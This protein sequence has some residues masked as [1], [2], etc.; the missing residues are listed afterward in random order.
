M[1]EVTHLLSLTNVKKYFGAVRAVDGVS[2]QIG[3][4]EIVGVVGPNGAGKTTLINLISGE[5]IPD[6]G[7]IRF[8]DLDITFAPIH[9]RVKL[10]IARSYQLPQIFERLSVLE[11]VLAGLLSYNGH[12]LDFWSLKSSKKALIKRAEEIL[13]ALGL[14]NKAT[15]EARKLSEGE[16]K[17]LDVAIAL[18]LNPKLLLL[19]E[20][21]TSVSL[22][23]KDMVMSVLMKYIKQHSISSVIVEH[24]LEVVEKYLPSRVLVMNEGKVIY[25]G[26]FQGIRLDERVRAVVFGE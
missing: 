18:T 9:K 19:D 20:P 5:L 7:R 25:D 22:E 2:F 8:K 14:L 10:G 23:E 15:V 13:D 4:G 17:I 3:Q 16:R 26:E 1:Q 21:T 6:G 24:D 11:N 12:A